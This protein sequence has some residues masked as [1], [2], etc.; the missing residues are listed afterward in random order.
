VSTPYSSHVF[1][2]TPIIRL[3]L[4][5]PGETPQSEERQAIID[6][7]SDFTIVPL[8]LLL[9]ID[10]PE[11][12]WA[13]LRGLWSKPRQVMLYLVDLHLDIGL[14]AGIEVASVDDDEEPEVILGRNVLNSLVLLL[15]GPRRQTDVLERRPLRL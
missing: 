1:P 8:D 10:A 15:D 2:P 4:A 3:R 5:V 9:D 7:G 12:R 11:S 14:L 13:Y 6:T